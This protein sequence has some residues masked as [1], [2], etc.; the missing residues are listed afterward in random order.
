M[1]GKGGPADESFGF[2][3]DT[4]PGGEPFTGL[5]CVNGCCCHRFNLGAGMPYWAPA[6]LPICQLNVLKSLLSFPTSVSPT[7]SLASHFVV[8]SDGISRDIIQM[9]FL[10]FRLYGNN[11]KEILT[12]PTVLC[13][14]KIQ[15]SGPMS[16]YTQCLYSL[17]SFLS[18]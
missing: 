9:P 2:D 15:Y 3:L 10:F 8:K 12:T 11:C 16:S 1:F 5:C 14:F 13:S 18:F 6:L 17:P 4:W 7:C